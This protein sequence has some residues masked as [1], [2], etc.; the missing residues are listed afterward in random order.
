MNNRAWKKCLLVTAAACL[1]L[2]IFAS[3]QD[4]ATTLRVVGFVVNPEEI[5]TPLDLAYQDFLTQ[6]QT[7]YP[8]VTVEA[9]ETPPEFDTQLLTDLAA[10]TA[11]DVWQQD[12]S[13]LARLIDSESILDIRQCM[14]LVPEMSLDRFFPSTLAIHQPEGEDGP[15]Y[16]LPNDFTPMV[17]YYNPVSFENAGVEV[18]TSDW[19]WDDF[20]ETTQRLTLDS[21]GR[22]ALDPDFD[23][24]DIAQY[25]VRVRHYSFE[26]LYWVWQNGGDVI[27]PDGTTVDGY[28]NSPE[29]IETI[30][31]LRD[32]IT[33]YHVSPEPTALA[34]MTQQAGFL[35]V[36]LEGTVAIFPRGHWELVGLRS[37][38]NYEEGRLAVVGNPSNVA[39]ATALFASGWAINAAVAEDPAKLQAACEMVNAAT[40]LDYQLTKNI[41]G[42]AIPANQEAAQAGIDSTDYPEIEQVFVEE[43]ANGRAPYG[44]RFAVWPV[45]ETRIDL[46]MENI[47]AGASVEEEV[48][49][50]VEEIDRELGRASGS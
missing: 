30:E 44:S 48:A 35:P 40:S 5:G 24:T 50:A 14:D 27:S 3:A 9:L 39:D 1:A 20:L 38:D 23:A 32:L 45:V 47:L 33:V 29:T 34:D 18:P 7:D 49:L 46:M 28:L 13:T 43:V 22:N 17:M 2:P 42:V 6:F 19:T 37:Q 4:E 31:F 41:T 12:A 26:W 11:P 25:G 15:I 36:F 16:G 8:N 21:Q 10:G